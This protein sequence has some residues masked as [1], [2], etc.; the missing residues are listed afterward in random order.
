MNETNTAR[1]SA[2]QQ[3]PLR[4]SARP[5]EADGRG[6]EFAGAGHLTTLQIK[7]Y[8][9]RGAD[10]RPVKCRDCDSHRKRSRALRRSAR[11][12][13][14]DGRGREFTDRTHLTDKQ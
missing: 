9:E 8:H 2:R 10:H 7:H 5:K 14:A 1:R 13:E 12:R 4:R 6:R 3:Q 11:P